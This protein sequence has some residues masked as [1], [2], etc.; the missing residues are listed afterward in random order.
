VGRDHLEDLFALRRA[1]NV[2]NGTK[3]AEPADFVALRERVRRV[4]EREPALDVRDLAVGGEDLM[5]VCGIAEGPE[6]GRVLRELLSRVMDDPGLNRRD[7]LLDLAREL[8]SGSG[9]S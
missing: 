3:E 4:L 9:S 2:G 1:D 5:R 8:G 6:V 7:R